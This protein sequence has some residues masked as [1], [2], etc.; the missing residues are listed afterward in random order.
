MLKF[1]KKLEE[2]FENENIYEQFLT[3]KSKDISVQLMIKV[4]K[5][6]KRTET[7]LQIDE[8][9][10]D[11]EKSIALEAGIYEYALVYAL[12]HNINSCLIESIY[13][14]CLE[15]IIIC[16]DEKSS[17]Y[18]AS[19]KQN[20]LKNILNPQYVAFLSPEQKNPELWADI[21]SKK[22]YE[23]KMNSTQ[24]TSNVYTCHKCGEKKCRITQLQT[25]CAD[26]P[27][28][29]FVSCMVCF[30]TFKK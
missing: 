17:K 1:D 2:Y 9:L 11:I 7:V 15:N 30:Y 21:I 28:T 14:D 19:L 10:M 23:E 4:D 26:E 12:T 16:I 13:N 20:I 8:Q 29:I 24:V 18:N 22:R 6:L 27:M 3:E 25:R 5:I